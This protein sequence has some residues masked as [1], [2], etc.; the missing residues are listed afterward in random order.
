MC[1]PPDSHGSHR[2]YPWAV[3]FI[4]LHLITPVPLETKGH[5]LA[6]TISGFN[7]AYVSGRC[8]LKM[9]AGRMLFCQ[10]VC[11]VCALVSLQTLVSAPGVVKRWCEVVSRSPGKH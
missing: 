11:N 2:E 7:A 4:S 5:I 1:V 6:S 10:C 8:V 3:P 9:A